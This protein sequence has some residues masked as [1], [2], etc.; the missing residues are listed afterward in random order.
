MYR[1]D[2]QKSK[3]RNVMQQQTVEVKEVEWRKKRSVI[4]IQY[5]K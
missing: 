4:F 3:R 5:I 1:L 2:T